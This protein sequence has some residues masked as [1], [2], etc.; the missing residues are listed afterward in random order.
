LLD[1]LKLI[2]S[3]Q[4]AVANQSDHANEDSIS[5][6]PSADDGHVSLSKDTPVPENV[7]QEL[8]EMVQTQL[9]DIPEVITFPQFGRSRHQIE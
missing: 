6:P 3:R 4:R 2:K 5:S 8:T 9:E 1:E 7:S